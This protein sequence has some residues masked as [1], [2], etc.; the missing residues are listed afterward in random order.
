MNIFR[1]PDRQLYASEETFSGYWAEPVQIHPVIRATG[2]NSSGNPGSPVYIHPVNRPT[3]PGYPDYRYKSI[4]LSGL[5][6]QIHP[7]IRN[8]GANLSGHPGYRFKFIR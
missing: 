7:V 4:R 3:G 5:S 8:T 6:V 2:P 1:N